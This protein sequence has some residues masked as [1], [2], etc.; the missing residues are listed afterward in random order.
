MRNKKAKQL[1]KEASMLPVSKDTIYKPYQNISFFPE[2]EEAGVVQM[3]RAKGIPRVMDVC[4]RS[5][6]KGMK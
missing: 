5:V 4:Q 1:R 3:K 6:Y 2:T